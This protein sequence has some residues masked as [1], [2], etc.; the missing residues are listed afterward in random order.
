MKSRVF[1]GLD[2]GT[3][4]VKCIAVDENGKTLAQSSYALTTDRSQRGMALQDPEEWKFAIVQVLKKTVF[5]LGDLDQSIVA[6]GVSTHGPGLVLSDAH[7]YE[8]APCAIWQDERSAKYGERL[9]RQIGYS[10]V[11]H[12]MPQTGL[13]A[14]ILMCKEETP[15]LFEKAAF[16]EDVKG[17]I[18]SFLT[19]EHVSEASSNGCAAMSDAELSVIGVSRERMGRLIPFEETAG[20]LKAEI[21][22]Q[23]GMPLQV[24]VVAGLNDGAAAMLGAGVLGANAGAVS[25]STNGVARIVLKSKPKGKTLYESGMFCWPYVE[26]SFVLGGFTKTAG[27]AVRWFIDLAYRGEGAPY[28]VLTDETAHSLPGANGVSFFPWL[29]GK[30]SPAASETPA[31]VFSGLSRSTTRGDMA[32]ALLEGVAYSI[33]DIGMH[34]QKLGYA[35]KSGVKITGGA[36]KNPVLCDILQSVSGVS[37]LRAESDSVLGA[38]LCAMRAFDC[39]SSYEEAAARMIHTQKIQ[40]SIEGQSETYKK[41][42]EQYLENVKELTPL[43]RLD[44]GKDGK[45]EQVSY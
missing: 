36:A 25:V 29:M 1:L 9:F 35:W 22:K 7:E 12:G 41:L 38:A 6:M 44:G 17:F 20:T 43:C 40:E 27:D 21:A 42:Y 32:R 30:G 34:F 2:L 33:W 13:A 14:R 16:I 39:F 45:H 31:G 37:L 18:L 23:C 5:L 24:Q 11:G 15:A 3:T 19:G 10:W 28:A 26:D 8:L 4:L